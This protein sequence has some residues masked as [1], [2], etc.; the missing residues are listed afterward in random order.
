MGQHLLF[1]TGDQT[2]FVEG[3]SNGC[4]KDEGTLTTAM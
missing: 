2:L 3:G 4:K 1:T